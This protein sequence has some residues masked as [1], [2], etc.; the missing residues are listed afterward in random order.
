MNLELCDK[1]IVITGGT[2]GLGLG[3]AEL[4]V[5]EGASVALC[6]RRHDAVEKAVAKLRAVNANAQVFGQAVD[7]TDAQALDAFAAHV[8]ERF[9]RVDGLVN[10][11]GRSAAMSVEAST[12]AMWSEDLDLKLFA[13][14]RTTR[15]FTDAL[16]LRGG[17]IVNVLA[18]SGKHPG[19]ATVPTSVSR[20]AG[21][22]FTKAASK[23]LGPRGIRVNAILIGLAESDQWVRRATSLGQDVGELTQALVAAQRVPLGRMGTPREFADLAAFLLSPRSSY[24]TGVGINFD[25]GLSSAV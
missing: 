11:A 20:A 4:L 2:E 7:V 12:D 14:I 9:G 24:V 17:S 22:A 10:N 8:L 15:L 5:E 18:I 3:L 25:G 13:A 6:S 19:Q 23:D 21:L 16:S 1:V